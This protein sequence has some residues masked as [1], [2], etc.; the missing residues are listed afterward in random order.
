MAFGFDRQFATDNELYLYRHK[1][2]S[3]TFTN[4]TSG[5]VLQYN[6]THWVN[7]PGT[8]GTQWF[9]GYYDPTATSDYPTFPLPYE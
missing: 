3:P 2:S 6:G 7:V 8:T 4:L 1:F 5:D 9:R